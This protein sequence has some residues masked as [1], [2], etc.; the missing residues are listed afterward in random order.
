MSPRPLNQGK[1]QGKTGQK[2]VILRD[3]S[4]IWKSQY[5]TEKERQDWLQMADNLLDVLA[6][7]DLTMDEKQKIVNLFI[8]YARLRPGSINIHS[9]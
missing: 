1:I 6:S 2:S 4:W 7:F 5:L 3:F 8:A 9:N